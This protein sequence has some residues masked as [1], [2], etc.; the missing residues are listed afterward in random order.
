MPELPEIKL[1][2]EQARNIW[3]AGLGLCVKTLDEVHERY[4]KTSTESHHLFDELVAKGRDVELDA[5]E[6]VRAAKVKTSKNLDEGLQHIHFTHYESYVNHLD[7]V[8]DK[9]DI[10]VHALSA[11]HMPRD[12][13]SASIKNLH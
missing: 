13:Q 1:T 4:D 6:K 11:Q 9:V 8:S 2:A 5:Q 7:E 10:I 3:F 12:P